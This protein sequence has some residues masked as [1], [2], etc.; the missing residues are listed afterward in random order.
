MGKLVDKLELGMNAEQV[1][2][3]V[4][5]AHY[6]FERNGFLEWL[7]Y[8]KSG[9]MK[10]Y[11]LKDRLDKIS[12]FKTNNMPSY[13]IENPESLTGGFSLSETPRTLYELGNQ[14][15]AVP[16]ESLKKELGLK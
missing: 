16:S 9:L 3:I 11:F 4:G 1:K 14:F 12:V 2:A 13:T 15:N 10:L 7:Y 5:K 8:N 6:T